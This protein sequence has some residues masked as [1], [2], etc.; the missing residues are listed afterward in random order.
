MDWLIRTLDYKWADLNVR[1]KNPSSPKLYAFH[2]L[3]RIFQII[4]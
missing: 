4:Q 3:I 2:S 1:P